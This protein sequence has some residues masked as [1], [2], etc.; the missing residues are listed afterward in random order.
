LAALTFL[1]C[2]RDSALPVGFP[3]LPVVQGNLPN[4]DKVALGR[5]LFFDPRLSADQKVSCATCHAPG[6]AFADTKELST[7]VLGKTGD[8][9]TPS[10]LNVAF[11]PR[12]L[13]D[14]T[15]PNLEEQVRYPIRHPQEMDSTERKAVAFQKSDN[16]YPGLFDKAF[17]DPEITFQ[18]SRKPSRA[19]SVR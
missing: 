8:R 17:S 4:A 12:L 9:N 11:V 15:V 1:V 16:Q 2:H 5:R 18:P 19:S 7:G 10:L 13:W 6:H 14:G 3:A